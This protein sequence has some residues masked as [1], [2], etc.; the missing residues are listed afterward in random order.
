[1][2]AHPFCCPELGPKGAETC[3]AWQSTL[4]CLW[5]WTRVIR[6]NS[7][8]HDPTAIAS[9]TWDFSVLGWGA[10]WSPFCGCWTWCSLQQQL[11]PQTH[12]KIHMLQEGGG[13]V[14]RQSA[15]E[16]PHCS[17]QAVKHTGKALGSANSILPHCGAGCGQSDNP[18]SAD[19]GY[20][21]CRLHPQPVACNASQS[22]H[23]KLSPT[24]KCT[25]A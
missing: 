5:L 3:G 9:A 25:H 17:A 4:W 15:E 8:R 11:L 10:L 13:R 16:P 21:V 7:V 1:M 18:G 22:D 2:Y 23:P 12:R 24:C 19:M 14:G 6:G 20:D